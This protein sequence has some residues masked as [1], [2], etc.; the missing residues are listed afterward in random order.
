MHGALNLPRSTLEN[1]TNTSID[2][3][4]G[5]KLLNEVK[6]PVLAI[7]G[8]GIEWVGTGFRRCNDRGGRFEAVSC[9]RVHRQWKRNR[10]I[11]YESVMNLT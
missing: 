10:R 9:S 2:E 7:G 11:C 8:V 1:S 6:D 4:V 3:L 5:N